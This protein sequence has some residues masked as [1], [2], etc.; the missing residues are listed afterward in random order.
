MTSLSLPQ[1]YLEMDKYGNII[2]I[3]NSRGLIIPSSILRELSLK[4]KDEVIFST[5]EGTLQIRKLEPYTGPFTGLFADLPRP[6]PGEQD[7]WNGKTTA[8][9]ME[10]YR[11]GSGC[12]PIPEW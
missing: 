12:R 10:E 5:K 2:R 3:G 1:I 9:I 8:E 4:E 11:G 7:P 6:V